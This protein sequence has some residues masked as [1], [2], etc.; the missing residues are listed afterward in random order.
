MAP[1]ALGCS[2]L[3][4]AALFPMTRIQRKGADDAWFCIGQTH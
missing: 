1:R 3:T 4:D 2:D